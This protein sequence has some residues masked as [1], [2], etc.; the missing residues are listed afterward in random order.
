MKKITKTAAVVAG[1]AVVIG[2]LAFWAAPAIG[3]AVGTA[4]GFSGAVA[5]NAGLA[6]L[7]GGA[8]AAGGAGMAGGT[9]VV[10]AVGAALGGRLGG[11]VSNSYFSDID[12]FNIR[13]IRDGAEPALMC[14]DG[15]LTQDENT[16]SNWLNN[17][18]EK[19]AD[20]AVYAVDWES[21][22]LHDIASMIGAIGAKQI[23][24]GNFFKQAVLKASK[25][26]AVKVGPLAG[27]LTAAD[28]I[29]NPWHVARY[30]AEEAGVLLADLIART[31]QTFILVG[32]SL[33]ARVIYFCLSAL[34][35]VYG[36]KWIDSVYLLGGA[37]N[38]SVTENDKTSINWIGVDGAVHGC[39]YNFYSSND[40]VLRYIYN[41]S[42]LFMGSS[43][44]RNPINYDAITNV[45]VS[46]L[47]SG[48][49]KYK[50]NLSKI[51]SR[52]E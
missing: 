16:D 21:K 46:D 6:A 7:G 39:I 52:I 27:L 18:P 26:A 51:I 17:L 47:V 11:V 44:G 33:G 38:N 8:L 42:Q 45:D 49:T 48:H 1:G 15:F 29:D 43:I 13:K 9:V 3:G 2:P 4:M 20:R 22:R 34:R 19:F 35:T 24:I 5:T 12:G 28:L 40:D 14:I 37:V 23:G 41:T 30:K 25:K 10:S 31:Q 32:H 50:D 36:K